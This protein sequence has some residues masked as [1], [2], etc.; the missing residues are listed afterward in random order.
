[1]K[2]TV[3]VKRGQR[4]WF[5]AGAG[6]ERALGELSDAA[7]KV[8]VHVCLRAERASGSLEF[9]R[10]ELARAVG[11][12]RSTLGRCLRELAGKGVC[13]LA[14]AAN[15]HGAS[16]LR[17]RPAYW[18]YEVREEPA[19]EQEPAQRGGPG[20][21]GEAS[22][23]VTQVRRMFCQPACVQ[24]RFGAAD[25]RLAAAWQRAGVPL[26]TVRRA[27]L[28]G[29]VRKSMSLLDRPGGE[30]VRSLRYFAGLLEEV[31]TESFPDSYWGH[32]EFNL[33]R[34]ERL[35]RNRPVEGAASAR[36][37]LAQAGSSAGI[38]KPSSAAQ[39][40]DKKETG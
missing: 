21:A 40:G 18:P 33:N 13:E 19:R 36:P 37:D 15:Q 4:G 28:L 23:Y 26:E 17:V 30:P 29:S 38:P 39:V 11:K 5:A 8:F 31:R 25:E 20:T 34:C 1:M 32:L 10:R 14:A 2:R 7:F 27:I 24:G 16:R 22:A 12:S 6:V 9:Q 3:R 35:W